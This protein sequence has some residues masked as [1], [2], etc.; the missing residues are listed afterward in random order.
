MTIFLLRRISYRAGRSA[1]NVRV[2]KHVLP[3]AQTRIRASMVE[4]KHVLV[5]GGEHRG[6]IGT[7]DSAIPGKSDNIPSGI[8]WYTQ[9]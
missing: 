5:I 9:L 7:I 4:G 2:S 3:Q 8:L 1:S 6:L